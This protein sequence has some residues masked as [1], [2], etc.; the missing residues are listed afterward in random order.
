VGLDRNLAEAWASSAAIAHRREQYDRAEAMFRRAIE[1]NPSYAPTYQWLSLMLADLGR[2]NEAVNSAQKAVELDP[3]S[4]VINEASG[5]MLEAAG[6]FTEAEARYLKALEIDPTMPG[7]YWEIGLLN[8]YCFDRFRLGLQW[9]EKAV[10]LDAGNPYLRNSLAVLY[11]DLGEEAQANEV[12][13]NARQRWPNAVLWVSAF[14]NRY[15]GDETGALDD[16]QELLDLDP[17]DATALQFLRNADLQAGHPEVARARY[18]KAYPELIAATI[19]RIDGSNSLP[20]TDLALVLQKTGESVRA[21]ELLDRSE[22]SNQTSTRLGKRGYGIADVQIHAMR[23][24]KTKALAALREAEKAGWRG[25]FWRY[26]RD[27][28]PNLAS[29]RN[30]PEFKAVFADIERDMARQRAELAKRPKDE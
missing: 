5:Q 12:I 10:D 24:D 21:R 27:F 26:Y 2:T 28:D 30:E 3:L 20:A 14:L 6:R 7:P 15:R 13:D 25:L 11:A 17:R 16:A 18:A 8:A 9:L 4:A 19:P 23:G 1:L 29:I 22:Q